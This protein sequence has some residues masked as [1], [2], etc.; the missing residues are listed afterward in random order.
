MAAFALSDP[1]PLGPRKRSPVTLG[2][3]LAGGGIALALFL[4]WS[5]MSAQIVSERPNEM[6]TTTVTL[7]PPPPPPPEPVEQEKPPEP[8]EAPPLEQPLDTPPPPDQPQQQSNEP[9]PGD[10]ALTARE[11]AGPSN[12]GLAAG[13]GSGTRIGSRPGGGNGDGFAAYG[14]FTARELQQAAQRD[15]ELLR[16]RYTVRLA[17]TVDESGRISRAQVIDGGDEKRNARLIALFTGLQLSRRPPAG[18]PVMRVELSA[19]S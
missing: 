1:D 3:V 7:P 13:N 18:L 14:N 8:T 2:R 11:G 19:R 12:Y 6:T 10:S 4:V 15:R 17:V 5:F 16:G 9:T